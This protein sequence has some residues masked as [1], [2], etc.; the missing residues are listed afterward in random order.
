MT[1]PRDPDAL[2][3]RAGRPNPEFDQHFLVDDRVL[4]RIPTYAEG[5]DRSHVLEIGAGTGASPT[6]CSPSPTT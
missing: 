3:R 2:I 1:D 4:D 5:F 6:A